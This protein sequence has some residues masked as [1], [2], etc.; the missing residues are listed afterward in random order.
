VTSQPLVERIEQLRPLLPRAMAAIHAAEE[1]ADACV[2]PLGASGV[3]YCRV[4]GQ[5]LGE[6]E[7]GHG[8]GCAVAKYREATR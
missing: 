5:A 8:G 6:D 4:C 1:L 2:K 7:R 3:N